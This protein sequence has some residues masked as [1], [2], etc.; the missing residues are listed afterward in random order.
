MSLICISTSQGYGTK[1][2][3]STSNSKP[4]VKENSNSAIIKR[5]NHHSSMVLAAGLKKGCVSVSVCVFVYIYLFVVFFHK[6][7]R[8]FISCHKTLNLAQESQDINLL[9]KV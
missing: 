7:R 3:P 9:L 4:T 8:L 1:V 5:F 6:L 2:A